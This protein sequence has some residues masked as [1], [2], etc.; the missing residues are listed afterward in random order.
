[1]R[2]ALKIFYYKKRIK[3]NKMGE[4]ESEGASPPATTSMMAKS[5]KTPDAHLRVEGEAIAEGE[6][7]WHE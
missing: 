1:M 2:S 7:V 3:D 5:A 6:E 4:S